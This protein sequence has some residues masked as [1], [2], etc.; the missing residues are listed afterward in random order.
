MAMNATLA[1]KHKLDDKQEPR[2]SQICKSQIT[3]VKKTTNIIKVSE[4][5][6][7]IPEHE[8]IHFGSEAVPNA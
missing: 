2:T 6:E 8:I 3:Q 5:R 7:P 4:R 1:K